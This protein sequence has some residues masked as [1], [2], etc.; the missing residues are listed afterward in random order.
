MSLPRG[1]SGRGA[2]EVATLAARQAA[3]ILR[4]RFTGEKRVAHKGRG[5]IVTQVDLEVE[6]RLIELLRE[7]YPDHSIMTEES[8]GFQGSS[9]YTWILDPLDGT[10]NFASG[11]PYFSVTVALARGEEAVVGI[12]HDPVRDEL[13][14]AE[15]GKGAFL[16]G[17]PIRV[18]ARETVQSSVIGFDM[19]Y[20][21]EKARQALQ[22]VTALW[23]GMQT[24]R[25]MG[26]AALGITYVACGRLDLY[27]HH[28]LYPWDLASGLLL[29]EEAGGLITDSS[30]APIGYTSKTAVAANPALHADFMRLTAGMPWRT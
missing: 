1:R 28:S 20:N 30:G 4:E 8:Q 9:P 12:V 11:I 25:V 3:E 23:P 2:L 26:S 5:N 27:F 18:S 21:D 24:M 17:S 7:E 10:R 22:M 16:N 15:K 14:W 13:F 29:V 19:G 6:R